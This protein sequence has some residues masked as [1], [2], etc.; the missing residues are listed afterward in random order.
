MPELR[1]PV[2]TPR[3]E[4]AGV[5][6]SDESALPKWRTWADQGAPLGR[7][8]R[9][10]DALTMAVAPGEWLVLGDRPDGDAV[11]LTH[12]RAALR[13]TG[14]AA[15]RLLEHVCGIDLDD[16]FTPDGAAARTLVAGVATELVRDDQD[17]EPSYLLLMSR[18]YAMWVHAH[19][20]E[21]AAHISAATGGGPPL[22]S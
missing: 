10:G 3:V 12:V 4:L 8:A 15:R 5:A 13:L 17:G 18:S 1:S 9:R 14:P 22:R 19:L 16:D 21:T 11:D 2:P 7:A 6:I 20:L